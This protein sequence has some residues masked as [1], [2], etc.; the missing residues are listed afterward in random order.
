MLF[1]KYRVAPD[2][3]NLY[4][5]YASRQNMAGDITYATYAGNE[6]TNSYRNDGESQGNTTPSY[7]KAFIMFLSNTQGNF[8]GSQ[9]ALASQTAKTQVVSYV[10][11]SPAPAFIGDFSDS[12][13][14][15]I[16]GICQ[17]MEVNVVNNY[18]SAVTV[19]ITMTS[20]L[21]N[22]TGTLTIPCYMVANDYEPGTDFASW[23]ALTAQ[24]DG[25]FKQVMEWNW[26]VNSDATSAFVLDLT[27]DMAG[28]NCDADGKVL[29]G[30]A[31]PTTQ[32]K[33]YYGDSQLTAV[34]FSATVPSAYHASGVNFDS[35]TG[36]LSFS[37][38]LAFE[39][40]SMSITIN[41]IYGGET[42][43]KVFTLMKNFPGADGTPATTTWI[44]PSA[45]Q[46]VL[47]PDTSAFTPNSISFA[48]WEQVGNNSPET[49]QRGV[50][51]KFLPNGG[52][53]VWYPSG[54]TVDLSYQTHS[55]VT[56]IQFAI[57]DADFEP[58]ELETVPVIK[59]GTPGQQGPQG[60]AGPSVRGPYDWYS[61]ITSNRRFCNG[62]GPYDTDKLYI[63]ILLKDHV[64]YKCQTSYDA[65]PSDTWESVSQNWASADTQYNFIATNLLLAENAKINFQTSN[66]LLLTDS[67]GTVTGGAQGGNGSDIA[68]WAGSSSPDSAPFQVSHNGELSA[69]TG[70]FGYMTI[71][72]NLPGFQSGGITGE[73]T[74]SP[75]VQDEYSIAKN[76]V[77]MSPQAI[78]FESKNSG[79]TPETSVVVGALCTL[80][81]MVNAPI[82]VDTGG[83]NFTGYTRAALD[84]TGALR[85]PL[86]TSRRADVPYA[87]QAGF[88][89]N[90]GSIMAVG[91]Y[92]IPIMFVT[93]DSTIFGKCTKGENAGYWVIN[94]TGGS[95][96][97]WSDGDGNPIYYYTGVA[98]GISTGVKY[99]SY[100]YVGAASS[101]TSDTQGIY[102]GHWG[103]FD[104]IEHARNPQAHVGVIWSGLQSTAATKLKHIIYL[105][106]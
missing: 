59:N 24:E 57:L 54:R 66:A 106:L 14:N 28:V 78:M 15:G 12:T 40:D 9:I 47:N 34:T 22:P 46:I 49:V 96:T 36:V 6:T 35:S 25:L 7:P 39:G 76:T 8:E 27:N 83:F 42:R 95:R 56:S 70:H 26:A 91:M 60:I 44:V 11:S 62:S 99:A 74:W 19:E 4:G 77:Y 98:S 97:A 20:G 13:S 33:L 58:Y 71:N 31:L 100:P 3:R 1:K 101:V 21:T 43:S 53:W 93:D 86:Y 2:G 29:P 45:N 52:G 50:Y 102:I 104:T 103:F 75:A 85:S 65:T 51:V 64:Y 89:G 73:Q 16:S 68:F 81:D 5:N 88:I 32:A 48:V 67:G 92:R 79:N 69:S 61:G 18:T 87:E 38:D 23:S 72:G 55:A 94:G 105:E 82:S 37:S 30:A 80:K 84:A 90:M 17:G 41:A 63:D 10:N